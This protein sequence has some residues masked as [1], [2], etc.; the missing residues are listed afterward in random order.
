MNVRGRGSMPC[1]GSLK[2]DEIKFLEKAAQELSLEE[3]GRRGLRE[4]LRAP[5]GNRVCEE[6][7]ADLHWRSVGGAGAGRGWDKEE[8][9]N[10]T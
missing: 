7:G 9:M 4:P 2:R 1:L 6:K 5:A 3:G 10:S 8:S